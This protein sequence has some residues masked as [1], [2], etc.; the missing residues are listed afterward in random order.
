M[1]KV[2][3][4]LL[5][6]PTFIMANHCQELDLTVTNKTGNVCHLV[7]TNVKHGQ[8]VHG[9]HAPSFIDNGTE[10]E[11]FVI[12]QETFNGPD[13]I[14]NFDCNGKS[15]SIEAHQDL[16]VLYQGNIVTRILSADN[17]GARSENQKGSYIWSTHGEVRWRL[18]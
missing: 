11:S 16:C 2:V 10:S 15:V 18:H 4:L 6:I 12:R 5:L 7:E 8:F 3:V 1:K 17:M 13:I 9:T 14:L